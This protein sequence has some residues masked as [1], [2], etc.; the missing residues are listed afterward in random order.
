LQSGL[1]DGVAEAEAFADVAVVEAA[2]ENVLQKA[3]SRGA[4]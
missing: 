3:K 1:L 2:P 4:L